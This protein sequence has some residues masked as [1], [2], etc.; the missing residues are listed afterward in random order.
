MRTRLR[1]TLVAGACASAVLLAAPVARGARCQ[2]PAARAA[3]A[4]ALAA[5]GRACDCRAAATHRRFVACAKDVVRDRIAAGLLPRACASKAAR[6]AGRSTCGRPDAAVCARTDARGRIRCR[7]ARHGVCRHGATVAGATSCCATC[8]AAACVAPSATTTTTATTSTTTAA[9]PAT[10]TTLALPA[11]PPLGRRLYTLTNG[12]GRRGG[13]LYSSAANGLD[14]AEVGTFDGSLVLDAGTPGPDGVAALAVGLD[15]I[16]GFR[17]VDGTVVCVKVEAAGSAGT[18]ACAG[19]VPVDVVVAADGGAGP[20]ATPSLLLEQGPP[21][22]PG[23][24]WV[25]A[26]VRVVACAPPACTV[27]DD[28]GDPAKVALAAAPPVR[29]AFTTGTTTGRIAHPR[30]GGNDVVLFRTGTP[31]R[32]RD[33][34]AIDGPGILEMSLLEPGGPLGD[35]VELLQLED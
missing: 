8:P 35:V 14:T 18:L 13:H 2:A 29:R 23:A 10:T 22:P 4:D 34:T 24:G 6:C 15:T 17:L 20:N 21:G 5:V 7:I 11:G 26:T 25:A 12:F 1:P 19:G 16:F 31:F 9:A 32:C 28:C 33:W 30:Q 27:V 3:V